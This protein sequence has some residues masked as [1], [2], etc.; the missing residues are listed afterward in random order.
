MLIKCYDY[1][2]KEFSIQDEHNEEDISIIN[3]TVITGD[4]IIAIYWNDNTQLNFDTGSETRNRDYYDGQYTIKDKEKIYKWLNWT[5][6]DD[7]T[8]SYMRMEEFA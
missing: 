7:R 3:V 1:D 6:T 5:G 4:E 2:N 8:Y